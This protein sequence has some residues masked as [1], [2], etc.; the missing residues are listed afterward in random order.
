MKAWTILRNLPQY[1][2]DAVEDEHVKH[3]VNKIPAQIFITVGFKVKTL[4]YLLSKIT[5]SKQ[6]Q[7]CN[8]VDQFSS[9]VCGCFTA[10]MTGMKDSLLL[11]TTDQ[12]RL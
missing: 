6:K 7:L 8:T 3:L 5:N 1:H 11:K 2:A 4:T 12:C 9:L 10:S